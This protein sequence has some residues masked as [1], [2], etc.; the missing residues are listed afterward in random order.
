MEL[1]WLN[2]IF[3]DH[4]FVFMYYFLSILNRYVNYFPTV[5]I[6]IGIN[7]LAYNFNLFL[8]F[9]FK[10]GHSSYPFVDIQNVNLG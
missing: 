4:S 1:F 9:L 10:D 8:L 2:I 5:F 7:Y 3:I 6:G